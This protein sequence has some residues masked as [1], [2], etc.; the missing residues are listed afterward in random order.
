MPK[1]QHAMQACV[2]LAGVM[3]RRLTFLGVSATIINGSN[4]GFAERLSQVVA[5]NVPHPDLSEGFLVSVIGAARPVLD[6][7]GRTG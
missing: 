7:G 3:Q 5:P 6:G 2:V 1:T 4:G